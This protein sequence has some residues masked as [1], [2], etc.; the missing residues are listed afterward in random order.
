VIVSF[1]ADVYEKRLEKQ[2]TLLSWYI[3]IH[4]ALW[5]ASV[6]GSYINTRH[7]CLLLKAPRSTYVWFWSANITFFGIQNQSMG[8][9]R[10]LAG[11]AWH[12][13]FSIAS[14]IF[15]VC[16]QSFGQANHGCSWAARYETSCRTW[17][18]CRGCRRWHWEWALVLVAIYF[19]CNLI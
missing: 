6:L 1:P 10:H 2:T 12:T 15:P 19:I 3:D 11:D 13:I 7:T 4:P 14:W 16:K 8:Y 5:G 18:P 9:W 17:R